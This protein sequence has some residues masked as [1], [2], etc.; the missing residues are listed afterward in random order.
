VSNTSGNNIAEYDEVDEMSAFD[1]LPKTFR[2][3][4]ADSSFKFGAIEMD[5]YRKANRLSH[6]KVVE[7]IKDQERRMIESQA[8][9]IWG[10]L[11]LSIVYP[12]V[13]VNRFGW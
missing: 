2:R 12:K 9:N 8:S 4:L 5:N 3:A 10:P 11:Y 1:R 6:H 13:K 7:F